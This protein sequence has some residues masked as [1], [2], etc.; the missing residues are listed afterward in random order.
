MKRIQGFRN[1]RTDVDALMYHLQSPDLLGK[2]AGGTA[3]L[4]TRVHT[5]CDF[6]GF[7]TNIQHLTYTASY[8]VSSTRT[9]F[10]M[11]YNFLALF[12]DFYRLDLHS[13]P[14]R[15]SILVESTGVYCRN[16]DYNASPRPSS[17]CPGELLHSHLSVSDSLDS[18]NNAFIPSPEFYKGLCECHWIV[19]DI[20]H[21]ISV[22]L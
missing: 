7:R 15:P 1:A 13:S 11:L 21:H 16:L 3:L 9:E 18:Y 8:A 5:R 19:L 4:Q 14:P 12:L 17:L 2:G 22:Y 6:D 20:E 10:S